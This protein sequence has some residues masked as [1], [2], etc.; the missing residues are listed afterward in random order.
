MRLRA[1]TLKKQNR[2]KAVSV[3]HLAGIF[4]WPA[5]FPQPSYHLGQTSTPL[6]LFIHPVL[7]C[8]KQ[9]APRL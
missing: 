2:V 1:R 8:Y 3:A 6:A 9:N 5:Y 4:L 7:L